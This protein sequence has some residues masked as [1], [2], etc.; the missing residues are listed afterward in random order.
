MQ[1]FNSNYVFGAGKSV[2][3]SLCRLSTQTMFMGQIKCCWSGYSWGKL[4]L[5]P[6]TPV[7]VTSQRCMLHVKL[8]N[9]ILS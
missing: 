6:L 7:A 4:A 9:P 5:C 1:T 3:G 2:R 8:H